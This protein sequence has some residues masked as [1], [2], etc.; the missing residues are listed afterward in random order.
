MS[1]RT[2]QGFHFAQP[3]CPAGIEELLERQDLGEL[4][5]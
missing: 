1:C 2:A 4:V 3:V 5:L